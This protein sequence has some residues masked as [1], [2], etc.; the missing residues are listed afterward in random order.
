VKLDAI[1]SK[2]FWN[3]K[4]GD[5]V[6]I[7]CELGGGDKL[8]NIQFTVSRLNVVKT[9]N[10]ATMGFLITLCKSP[11]TSN[12]RHYLMEV[13]VI[14]LTDIVTFFHCIGYMTSN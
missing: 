8:M 1:F 3:F 9:D 13:L 5:M 11:E 10:S 4:M 6:T 12:T 2:I 7:Y 14:F